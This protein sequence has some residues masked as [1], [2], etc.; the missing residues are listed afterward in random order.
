[1]NEKKLTWLNQL[2]GFAIIMIVT[3]HTLGYCEKMEPLATYI[4]SFVV[5]LF[6]FISGYLFV[7]NKN[8]SVFHYAKRKALRV[9]VPYFS[10]ALLS[11]IPFYMFAQGIQSSLGTSKIIHD[12]IFHSLLS[13]FYASGHS[14]WLA[15]NSPLW[16]LPCYFIVIVAGKIIYNVFSIKDFGK[17]DICFMI[18]FV[19]IGWIVY[20]FFNYAYPFCLETAVV[21]LYFYFFGCLV[22]KLLANTES[23]LMWLC[24]LCLIIGFIVHNYN[25]R[26]S[27]MNNNYDQSYVTFIIAATL[28]GLGYLLLFRRFNMGKIFSY[29]GINTLPILVFH[30]MPLVVFQSSLGPVS[31]MLQAG[32]AFAELVLALIF[33]ALSIICSLIA[34]QIMI[35]ICPIIY[36]ETKRK[37]WLPN[38]GQN[39][40]I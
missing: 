22:R 17:Q 13:I 11:L 35:R 29:I 2:R 20:K 34:Y 16:F 12:N 26:I 18:F 9:L 40:N 23:S 8:E 19:I 28:T 36:G 38:K 6:F 14:G 24:T 33:V 10:F 30:K 37:P 3:M 27:C 39:T 7:N 15:Q 21:M 4:G 32:P 31:E 5:P 1:M 25:G